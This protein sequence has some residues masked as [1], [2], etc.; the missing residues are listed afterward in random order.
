MVPSRRIGNVIVLAFVAIVQ[1]SVLAEARQRSVG[2]K[3]LSYDKSSYDLAHAS[4]HRPKREGNKQQH[5]KS[6]QGHEHQ[7][8]AYRTFIAKQKRSSES[9]HEV[10]SIVD[11]SLI[12]KSDIPCGLGQAV[13][14][15]PLASPCCSRWGFCGSG[16]NYCLD[17]CQEAFGQ[18]GDIPQQG[19]QKEEEYNRRKW[20]PWR[21]VH[22][23]DQ[24]GE[25]QR[26]MGQDK[27]KFRIPSTVPKLPL[28]GTLVN[29]AYYAG[30]AQY[31]GLG[32]TTCRQ[33]PYLP[34]AIPWSSL[35]YVMFAFAYFDDDNEL[36]PA[37]PSDER[38]YFSINKLKMATKTRV[39]ISIGGWTFTHPDS[40]S[41]SGTKHRFRNM[42]RSPK[43][44]KAFIA[45]CIEYCQ[46][47]GFD[48]V[49][50]DYEYPAYQDRAFVTALFR[51]M[52]EAFD[53]E[54][55]GLIISMAGAAFKDGVQGFELDKVAKY[56]DFLMI[57]TYDLYGS[58]DS[59]RVVNIHTALIQ[60]PDEKHSGH[61]VQ[62][63]VELYLDRG[64]PREKIVLGLA[65]YAKTFV[66]ANP[67][68]TQPG[69]AQF[70]QGGDPTNCMDSRGEMAYNEIAYLIHPADHTSR[71]VSPL[72]DPDGR[73][74]YFVYGSR[75]DNLVGYDDRPSLDLK[76]QLVTELKLAGVMWWSLDQDLDSTSEKPGT[77]YQKRDL[78]RRTIP[79]VPYRRLGTSFPKTVAI[80]STA[81]SE[82][83]KSVSAP[84]TS[85]QGENKTTTH[86]ETKTLP[87]MCPR[88]T[89]A[90]TFAR[91][92]KFTPA[93]MVCSNRTTSNPTIC[94]SIVEP[95]ARMSSIPL[96]ILGQPGLVPY[97]ASKRK[98]CRVVIQ[99]PHVLPETPVG[100]AV[101]KKC[102][103]PADCT[104]SWQAFTCTH[105]GWSKGSP[106]Y[107]K[108]KLS[109]SLYFYGEL[110][111]VRTARDRDIRQAYQAGEGPPRATSQLIAQVESKRPEYITQ[112]L[113]LSKVLRLMAEV[114]GL[115]GLKVKKRLVRS[116]SV[117]IKRKMVKRSRKAKQQRHAK[118]KLTSHLCE[119]QDSTAVNT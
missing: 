9:N 59:N 54:G 35:D 82:G 22:G 90:A 111:F 28:N 29:I 38:L 97:V 23:F 24:N 67:S 17:G 106:C 78:E 91:L 53:A 40:R 3:H 87:P 92:L 47:Y 84:S 100:N 105:E 115:K 94:P 85:T 1:L 36:Y 57:M 102:P 114:K 76:L 31:R 61:S 4:H 93:T 2:I 49:D 65:L 39:M 113:K 19:S 118:G 18:C 96:N 48:G 12:A 70:K 32:E 25:P 66:L 101:M 62:G 16:G 41:K 64:V 117:A 69:I 42:V 33:R 68:N 80:P 112:Y 104:E 34:S 30:W 44:R 27:S 86:Q 77:H 11:Q 116:G 81:S 7:E 13:L 60:M 103:A 55:S 63:A 45:S 71:Q 119:R 98:R 109:P 46:S 88:L 21:E 5:G 107:D 83:V 8:S 89:T 37:D 74:F 72:W 26:V 20:R 58:D 6:N 14:K 75:Q 110:E 10:D 95:P 99:Y 15:C 108:A 52:R 56:M 73:V 50:I 43:S 51:E 79:Q